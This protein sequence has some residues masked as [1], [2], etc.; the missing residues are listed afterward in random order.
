MRLTFTT[1]LLAC[2]GAAWLFTAAPAEAQQSGASR[3]TTPPRYITYE[4]PRTR[5]T[6]QRGRSYLD[7]GTEVM[8]YSQHYTDYVF[9]NR[10][11]IDVLGPGQTTDRQPFPYAWELGGNWRIP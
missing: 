4:R 5:V 2:A 1:A 8:P 7:P 9:L 3:R 11:P 10:R 6:V